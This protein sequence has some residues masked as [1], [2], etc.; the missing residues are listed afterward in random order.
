MYRR[1]NID[2]APATIWLGVAPILAACLY[3]IYTL[4]QYTLLQPLSKPLQLA[5]RRLPEY[6][7]KKRIIKQISN[8]LTV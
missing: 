3:E 5:S 7:H 1:I 8:H 6:A 4:S 2:K